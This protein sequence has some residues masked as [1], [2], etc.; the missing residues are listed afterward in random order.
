[1]WAL[2]ALTSI[3]IR[4]RPTEIPQRHTQRRRQWEDRAGFEDWSDATAS[5][6]R[7]AATRGWTR[8]GTDSPLEPLERA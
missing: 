5:A 7:L 2:N 4:E 8:Q 1:M 6:G 3:L